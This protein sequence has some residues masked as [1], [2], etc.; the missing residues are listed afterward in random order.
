MISKINE[1][2]FYSLIKKGLRDKKTPSLFTLNNNISN[3]KFYFFTTLINKIL[4]PYHYTFLN[5]RYIRLINQPITLK[6]L[7]SSEYN[8]T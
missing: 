8:Q 5:S 2:T 7:F 3:K 6:K 1:K 4:H